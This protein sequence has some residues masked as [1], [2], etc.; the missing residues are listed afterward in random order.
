M[1]PRISDALALENPPR[2]WVKLPVLVNNS[3]GSNTIRYV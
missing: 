2:F 1:L 3:E